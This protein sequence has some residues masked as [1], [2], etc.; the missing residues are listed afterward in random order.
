[1]SGLSLATVGPLWASHLHLLKE[2][3]HVEEVATN[4]L[5]RPDAYTASQ[6]RNDKSEMK[7]WF[8]DQLDLRIAT[9]R[10]EMPPREWRTRI[11]S[12]E[13]EVLRENSDYQVITER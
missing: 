7:D 9:L 10:L 1:M 8:A 13:R 12:L 6:A 11:R 2:F 3:A 5:A 4:P